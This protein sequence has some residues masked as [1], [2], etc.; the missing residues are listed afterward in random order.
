ML[1]LSKCL[2]RHLWWWQS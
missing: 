2:S 1:K